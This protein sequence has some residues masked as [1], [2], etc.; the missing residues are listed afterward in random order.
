[1]VPNSKQ[2]LILKK[3]KNVDVLRRI[4]TRLKVYDFYFPMDNQFHQNVDKKSAIYMFQL[5]N[6]LFLRLV[7]ENVQSIPRIQKQEISFKFISLSVQKYMTGLMY[8]MIMRL[9]LT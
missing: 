7:F 4:R 1:M 6:F 8:V 9:Y 3:Y 5:F 2:L